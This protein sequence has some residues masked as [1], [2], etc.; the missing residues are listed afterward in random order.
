[1]TNV[2]F[3]F[4]GKVAL[5]V[6][7]SRG[8]GKAVVNQLSEAGALVYYASRSPGQ[9]GTHIKCDITREEELNRLFDHFE[10]IDF[11]IN[12]AGTNLCEPIEN[13]DS[14]EWDRVLTTN[15]KSFFLICKN[16]YN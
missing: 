2:S 11:V 1:M 16:I 13:I 7:G 5:V 14:G 3:D 4:S 12:V 9:T 10:K 6:G 15:L 8:I